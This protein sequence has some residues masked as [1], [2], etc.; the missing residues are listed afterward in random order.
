MHALILDQRDFSLAAQRAVA[1]KGFAVMDGSRPEYLGGG[2]LRL[3]LQRGYTQEVSEELSVHL[4]ENVQQAAQ[5][6]N[7]AAHT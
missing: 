5:R 7:A 3:Y 1:R 6:W 4:L 2:K